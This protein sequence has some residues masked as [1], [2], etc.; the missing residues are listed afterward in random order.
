M[1]SHTCIFKTDFLIIIIT[2]SCKCKLLRICS[3]TSSS[4]SLCRKVQVFFSLWLW[5]ILRPRTTPNS[6]CFKVHVLPEGLGMKDFFNCDHKTIAVKHLLLC[7]PSWVSP[8]QEWVLPSTSCLLCS[9]NQETSYVLPSRPFPIFV[10]LLW[11]LH[12]SFISIVL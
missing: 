5:F 7:F 9:T 1:L 3:L 6:Y 10:A 8:R 4:V 11:A 12:N 2:F